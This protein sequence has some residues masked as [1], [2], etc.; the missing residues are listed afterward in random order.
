MVVA[1]VEVVVRLVPS[2]AT[3]NE[4]PAGIVWVSAP[5]DDWSRTTPKETRRARAVRMAR[6]VTLRFS[7]KT[8]MVVDSDPTAR[9]C[10]AAF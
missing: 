4:V 7:R 8:R 5:E 2:H 1:L 3:C 10:R 6:R 9:R